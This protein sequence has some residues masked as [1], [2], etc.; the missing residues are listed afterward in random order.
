MGET[1]GDIARTLQDAGADAI[2]LCTNTMHKVAL[3]E[4]NS[5]RVL[6]LHYLSTKY[7][8]FFDFSLLISFIVLDWR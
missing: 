8:C 2:V 4:S 3:E 6:N 1:L 7:A 5:C